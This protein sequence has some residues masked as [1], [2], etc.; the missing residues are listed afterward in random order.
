MSPPYMDHLHTTATITDHSES[1]PK[2]YFPWILKIFLT[3]CNRWH[4]NLCHSFLGSNSVFSPQNQVSDQLLEKQKTSKRVEFWFLW[5]S[6]IWTQWW[7]VEMRCMRD[8]KMDEHDLCVVLVNITQSLQFTLKKI[9]FNNLEKLHWLHNIESYPFLLSV[10]YS[11]ALNHS[12]IIDVSRS[13]MMVFTVFSKLISPTPH[14]TLVVW[15]HGHGG[16]RSVGHTQLNSPR[17]RNK[18]WLAHWGGW[19]WYWADTKPLQMT[20]N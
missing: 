14:E 16:A 12:F 15:Y 7:M 10:K 3:H 5:T 2:Y 17:K 20:K 8:L 9:I 6:E 11:F 1:E 18:S 19:S 4:D 13:L